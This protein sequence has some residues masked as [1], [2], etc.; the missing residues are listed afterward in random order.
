MREMEGLGR[1]KDPRVRATLLEEKCPR[2]HLNKKLKSGPW[3]CHHTWL[4]YF[5]W[6]H[7]S[8]FHP[9]FNHSPSVHHVILCIH[10]YVINPWIYQ[11]CLCTLSS[12]SWQR[13]MDRN[14]LHCFMLCRVGICLTETLLFFMLCLLWRGSTKCM[15]FVSQNEQKLMVRLWY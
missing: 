9:F 8:L 7:S 10:A 1:N 4:P 11:S 15:K 3:L 6:T 14:V 12:L 13:S 5:E 2:S